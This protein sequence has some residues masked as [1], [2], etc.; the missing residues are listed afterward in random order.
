MSFNTA[1]SG[2]SYNSDQSS[3]QEYC[4]LI[5]IFDISGKL[6]NFIEVKPE[7]NKVEIRTEN[8]SSGIYQ[9]LYLSDDDFDTQKFIIQ[10]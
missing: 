10:H 1:K 7:L 8:Y 6:I 4:G 9:L 5:K 2:Q 3:Q